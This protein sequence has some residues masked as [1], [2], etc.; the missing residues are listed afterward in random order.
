[1]KLKNIVVATEKKGYYNVLEQSCQ[2][3]NIE[4]IPLGLGQKWTGFTMRYKLLHEYLKTLNEEEI[5]MINDAYDVII[6]ENSDIIIDK[7]K[8]FN[9]NIVFCTQDSLLTRLVFP[10]CKIYENIIAIGSVIGYVKY[11]KEM[12]ELLFKYEYLWEKYNSD[13][14]IILQNT[15]DLEIN[16]FEKNVS[17]DTDR[18]LFFATVSED[19]I[20]NLIFKDISGLYMKN[21]KLYT[22]NNTTPSILHLASNVDGEKYLNLFPIQ[23]IIIS[24][25]QKN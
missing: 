5:V 12:V 3:H 15:C 18:K 1:M 7:F 21:N 11:L 6:L 2:R 10:K 23:A 24:Q 14:Q 13:D 20:H 19:Y 22:K 8:S 25:M 9:K 17:I 16:F 4:L